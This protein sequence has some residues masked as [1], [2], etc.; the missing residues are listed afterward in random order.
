MTAVSYEELG[1]RIRAARERAGLTQGDLGSAIGLDRTAVNKLESGIRR[2]TAV[3]L[4]DIAAAVSERMASFFADPL[5]AIV[6]HRAGRDVDASDARIDRLLVRLTEDVEL[7]DSLAPNE[8]ALGA[9]QAR[10]GVASLPQPDSVSAADALAVTTREL[11]GLDEG[12]PL[13]DLVDRAAT[14]GLLVFSANLGPDTADAG[15]VLLRQGGV[16]LVNSHSKV[17]RR[18]LAGAH[19]LGHYLVADDYTIDWRVTDQNGDTEARMDRFA[20]ALL[21]PERGITADWTS[22]RAA[23][24]LR[25][26]AVQLASKYRVDMTTLARRLQDLGL[27]VDNEASAI[28]SVTTTKADI[29]EY[30][31]AVPTDLAE[32]TQPVPFQRAVLKALRDERVSRARA[33]ELLQDTFTESDLPSPRTRR[34]D[35]IWNFVA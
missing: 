4:A 7:V 17:G 10:V 9:F 27:I 14:I 35:E 3:E 8:L 12:E 23:E 18:R 11:L 30:G 19:E 33:L 22:M 15:T 1:L 5:P 24:D 21:L 34:E 6:S 28:R 29:V 16:S 31:L 20:R 2:V 26:S 25:A 32:T 13:K